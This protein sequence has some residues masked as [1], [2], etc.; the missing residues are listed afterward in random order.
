MDVGAFFNGEGPND[1]EKEST[2]ITTSSYARTHEQDLEGFER[3]GTAEVV[4]D[5]RFY[6][7]N[8]IDKRL[9]AFE[10]LAIVTEIMAAEAVK[11][12]FELPADFKLVGP[13]YHVAIFQFIGFSVMVL[14]LY[15]TTVTT[16]VLSLQLFF[17]DPLDDSWTNRL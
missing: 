11:Q 7:E 5:P 6:E 3:H 17:C 13:L 16:A 14:V 4:N 15:L 10:A 2:G 1:I 8:V 9:A 12:C